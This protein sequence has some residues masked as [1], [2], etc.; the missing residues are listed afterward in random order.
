MMTRTDIYWKMNFLKIRYMKFSS[1]ILA[2]VR[3]DGKN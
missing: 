2:P 3:L 1:V